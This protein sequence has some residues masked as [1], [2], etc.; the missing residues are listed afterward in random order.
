[1][2]DTVPL[3]LQHRTPISFYLTYLYFSTHSILSCH[4]D[5]GSMFLHYAITSSMTLMEWI[6][7]TF[8]TQQPANCSDKC[9][10]QCFTDTQRNNLHSNLFV[11]WVIHLRVYVQPSKV[12]RTAKETPGNVCSSDWCICALLLTHS[13]THSHTHTQRQ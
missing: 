4:G 7:V 3:Q 9:A 10:L 2:F 12:Y 8:H 11:C 5:G 13:V 6:F 1:M